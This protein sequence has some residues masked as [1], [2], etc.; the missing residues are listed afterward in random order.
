M[1]GFEGDQQVDMIRH[2]ANA[3]RE[4]IESFDDS[5]EIGVEFGAPWGGDH[6]FPVLGGEYQEVMERGVGGGHD[7]QW[8]APLPGCD[9]SVGDR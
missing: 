4:S 1:G 9:D 7:G 3:M 5:A 2:A 6:R 8:L